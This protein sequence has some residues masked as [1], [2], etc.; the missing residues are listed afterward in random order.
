MKEY[1]NCEKDLEILQAKRNDIQKSLSKL[2]I[3]GTAA[4]AR[5]QARDF[6]LFFQYFAKILFFVSIH[7]DIFQQFRLRQSELENELDL[8]ESEIGNLCLKL[9]Q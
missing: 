3:K 1:Q 6:L 7:F 2:K 5:H 4:A 9:R 8:L